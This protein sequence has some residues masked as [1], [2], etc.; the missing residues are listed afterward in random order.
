MAKA[1]KFGVDTGMYHFEH[2]SKKNLSEILG[3][4]FDKQGSQ[5]DRVIARSRALEEAAEGIKSSNALTR[6]FV[7]TSPEIQTLSL[8]IIQL[9]RA[10]IHS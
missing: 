8:L 6:K 1:A 5:M 4:Y 10:A 3:Q 2:A 7:N 9:A